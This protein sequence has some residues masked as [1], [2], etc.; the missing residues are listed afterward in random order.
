[1][2]QLLADA[3]LQALD[4]SISGLERGVALLTA[5][6]VWYLSTIALFVVVQHFKFSTDV[7]RRAVPPR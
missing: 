3:W 1:M 2:V 6:E 4:E 5:G 7:A